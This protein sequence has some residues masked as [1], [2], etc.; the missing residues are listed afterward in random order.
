[1]ASPLSLSVIIP[2]YN[3][4]AA[5][6][7][8]LDALRRS[9][10]APDEVI[11]VADGDTDGSRQAARAWGAR[12]L[13]NDTPQGPAAARN[14][15]V[16]AATGDLIFFI[17]ADVAVHPGTVGRVARAF[18]E[19]PD[20]DAL[21]GSYD[22]RPADLGF[23]S[24]YRNLLHHFTHQHARQEASTFWGACGAVRR[25]AFLSVGGFDERHR[26]PSIE[27]IELGYRLTNAGFRI[28]LDPAVQV[29]HLKRWTAAQML[30]TDLFQRGVP[31]T[32]LILSS[33]QLENDLNVDTRSRLSVVA[34]GALLGTLAGSVVSPKWL[35]PAVPL[36]GVFITLNRKFYNFLHR[37]RG[38]VFM[39][40]AIPWHAL[41][42]A[43]S[44]AAFA[45][46]AARHVR[47]TLLSEDS[48][49]PL[50]GSPP[51]VL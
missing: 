25:A 42:Y 37:R 33:R 48:S 23:L 43:C 35:A 40:K 22:D 4:G 49:S 11:V 5:F 15:G 3:G 50:S 6:Q 44:G 30:S 20:L 2:V 12:V 51:Q 9:Q 34:V 7:Q 10:R 19:A 17:D 13:A 41:Y 14:R 38:A 39:L 46:G 32:E 18:A 31:W 1:M 24:Q 29:T 47:S 8:C 27:D 21:I 45:L 26:Q 36:T 28:R 16:H